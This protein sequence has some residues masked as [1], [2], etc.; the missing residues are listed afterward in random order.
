MDIVSLMRVELYSPDRMYGFAEF[1]QDRVFFHLEAFH[2]EGGPPPIIGEEVEV[3]L[4]PDVETGAD[5]APRALRVRRVVVPVRI[6]GVV[7]SFNPEKG[8]GFVKGVD[9]VSYYLH[10]SE[11]EDG[12]LPLP[13]QQATFF[14]GFKRDRPRACYVQVGRID[15]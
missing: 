10:R 14:K 11:V 1:G 12:R 4:G 15:G 5:K 3:E 7:E 8:W 13:N 6:E 9:G 2:A